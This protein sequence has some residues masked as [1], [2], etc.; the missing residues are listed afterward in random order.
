MSSNLKMEAACSYEKSVDFQ[1]T[2]RRHIR[3]DKTLHN[4]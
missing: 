3:K 4:H 2:T 1:W